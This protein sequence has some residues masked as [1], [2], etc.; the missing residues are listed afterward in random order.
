MKKA[1]ALATL[2]FVFFLTLTLLPGCANM[3]QKDRNTDSPALLEPQAILKF[4]DVPVPVG[5]RQIG[6]ESYSFESGGMRVAL[7]K[8]QGKAAQDQVVNFYK[9]QMAMY[10]WN[11]LNVVEYGERM[12]NFDRDNETCIISLSGKGNSTTI[13]ITL[14]PKTQTVPKKAREPL[15]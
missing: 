2:I 7:L 1:A 4:N 6:N 13:A 3:P 5:F 12:L 15:K 9:E 11:L 10:N 14:G 8:Y